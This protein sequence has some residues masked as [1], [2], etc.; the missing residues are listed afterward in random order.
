MPVKLPF[1]IP[2]FNR[3]KVIHENEVET[4]LNRLPSASIIVETKTRQIYSL[5][6]KASDL[7]ALAQHDLIGRQIDQFLDFQTQTQNKVPYRIPN[8]FTAYLKRRTDSSIPIQVQVEPISKGEN[9]IL[10][11]IQPSKDES[12][13]SDNTKIQKAFWGKFQLLLTILETTNQDDQLDK[14]L[15][16]G[17]SLTVSSSAGIYIASGL[18]PQLER[19][20][21]YGQGKI[22]PEIIIAPELMQMSEPYLWLP[23]KSI[24]LGSS[25]FQTARMNKLSYLVTSA[26]GGPGATIGLLVLAD[27]T[28][29]PPDHLLPST[30]LISH[31]ISLAISTSMIRSEFR[32]EKLELNQRIRTIETAQNANKEGIF[33]L[34][35]EMKILEI[36]PAAN[37]IFGYSTQD[38]INQPIEHIMV[39]SESLQQHLESM[40][41]I[42]KPV[43]MD[44]IRLFRRNGEDFLASVDVLPVLFHG[45]LSSII[46]LIQDL[47][48]KENIRLQTE[49]LEQRALL[50]E[51]TAIFAHE[52]RNPIN[53]I[54]TGLQLMSLNLPPNDPNQEEIT[55]LQQDCDRLA[56]LMKS[57]LSMSKPADYNMVPLNVGT[58]IRRL[59]DRRLS[60][61]QNSNIEHELQIHPDTPFI[62]GDVRALEQIFNNLINNALQS[63]DDTGGNLAIKIQPLESQPDIPEILEGQ[64]NVEISVADTGPGIPKELQEKIFQPFFT[65]RPT[66]TGLGLAIVKRNVTF[67]KGSLRV[68]SFPGGTIFYVRLPASKQSSL[69]TGN[70]D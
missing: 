31:F 22:L 51:V 27:N 23:G 12:T 61:M 18:N 17:C 25:L 35:P 36:N 40:G 46:I 48:E 59:L 49:Q 39:G 60:R 52:V 58:L 7:F 42:R 14:I 38:A 24:G 62:I 57:V 69:E 55:R 29:P 34:S 9:Y 66:G 63:M 10:L 53:N 8:F 13:S 41:K 37:L 47:S 28:L 67:H 33:F 5:N 43:K 54:S 11:T 1:S 26:I 30:V 56:E 21:I 65:T 50:G 45:T 6:Q 2:G 44:P 68:E 32:N 70:R 4:I 64:T 16:A 15:E 3:N 20:Y 19:K